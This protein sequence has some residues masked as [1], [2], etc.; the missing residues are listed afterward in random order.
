MNENQLV[1]LFQSK[2]LSITNE[3]IEL[4]NKYYEILIEYNKKVNLTSITDK[5]EVYLKHFYDSLTL[6]TEHSIKKNATICDIGAGAGFPSVPVKI[7]RPDLTVTIVDSLG[8]RIDFLNYLFS[9]LKLE[10]ITAIND[11]A[12]AFSIEHRESFDYVTA[13]AVARLNILSELC[14]PLVKLNG[15][16]IA[17]KS[18]TGNEELNEAKKAIETLGCVV[19]KNHVFTLPYEGGLRN[20]IVC[21][22]NSKTPD[23]YPRNYSQIKNKPL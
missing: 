7:M 15:E 19:S 3:Q 23:K 12:E 9:K 6:I 17:M 13:R 8:K 2:D 5:G 1:S 14:I 4:L 16:F 11:R 20:I 10:N 18:T 22:K 21:K